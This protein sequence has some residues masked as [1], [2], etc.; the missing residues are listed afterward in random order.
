MTDKQTRR[1]FLERSAA[2][3]LAVD[4]ARAASA[5][6][7]ITGALIGCGGRGSYITKLAAA[8]PD[9]T[10]AAVCDVNQANLERAQ[11]AFSGA[12]GYAEYRRVLERKDIDAVIVATPTHWHAA[13]T[14]A[15]CEAGKDVYIEK[16]LGISIEECQKAVA[17]VRRYK[18]VVQ[19]GLQQRSSFQF[20][21][22]RRLIQSG[23]IGKVMHAMVVHPGGYTSPGVPPSDPPP[24]LDWNAWQGPAPRHPYSR[25]RHRNWQAY[26]EYGGGITLTD[27]AV[28]LFD[29]VAW[30]MNAKGPRTAA[31]AS[32]NVLRPADELVPDSISAVFQYD[33]FVMNFTNWSVEHGE[34]DFYGN[35][36]WGSRGVL[37]VNRTKFYVKPSYYGYG[38]PKTEPPIRPAQLPDDEDY[39]HGNVKAITAHIRNFLDCIKSRQDPICPIEGGFYA[40]LPSLLALR[41]IQSGKTIAWDGQ[42]T[43]PA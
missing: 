19:V 27:W 23:Y 10:V 13:I 4:R 15:A 36:F 38:R 18:R 28:H 35:Y 33:N 42:A 39:V 34:F 37:F 2:A 20:Q 30:C 9:F 14:A 31:V 43:R 12:Q 32:T 22:A 40:T 24:G 5:N 8:L 25:S 26:F 11:T 16:P 17:A 1:A 6:D 7:R 21:E 3:G 29:I 41:S